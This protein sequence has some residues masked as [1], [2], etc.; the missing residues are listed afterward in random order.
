[1]TA[2]S[3]TI[4]CDQLPA[5]ASDLLSAGYRLALVAGHDDGPNLRVVYLF[6]DAAADRQVE[7]TLEISA[8]EPRI[9]SLAGLSFPAGRF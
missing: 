8:A 3:R 1:M 5:A 6:A 4:A 7:L 9:P 2:V